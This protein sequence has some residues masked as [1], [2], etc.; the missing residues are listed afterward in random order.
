MKA[1]VLACLLAV[2]HAL[3]RSLFETAQTR[4]SSSLGA[5]KS[6][7]MP[8]AAD[9]AELDRILSGKQEWED[10]DAFDWAAVPSNKPAAKA[11]KTSPPATESRAQAQPPAAPQ[12]VLA[13]NASWRTKSGLAPQP[14]SRTT[15][16]NPLSGGGK[17]RSPQQAEGEDRNPFDEREA[18][19]DFSYDDL[20]A[21]MWELE[22]PTSSG[23]VQGQGAKHT[24]APAEHDGLQS[25]AIIDGAVWAGLVDSTY[26][27]AA[28]AP[29]AATTTTTAKT[30]KG[31]ITLKSPN[32]PL[33]SSSPSGPKT[34]PFSLSR[35][36]KGNE[37][38]VVIVY[39]DPRRNN[40]EFELTLEQLAKVPAS[41]LKVGVLA[42]NMD[43]AADQRKW[44]KRNPLPPHMT[45]ACDPSKRLMESL[46]AKA[47]GRLSSV[48][49][50]LETKTNRVLKIF[51]GGY[52]VFSTADLLVEE[53]R[54]YRRDPKS[55][56]Q[57]QIGVR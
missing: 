9:L 23:L 15:S 18:D 11:K 40:E 42:V 41:S 50:L 16:T 12:P 34:P 5:G 55:F 2:A 48:L 35:V 8:S 43:D 24:D 36:S 6:N 47:R 4:R 31:I 39:A 38:D 25:G 49:L 21:A 17:A 33:S 14:P 56:I 10:P 13:P 37:L 32:I 7:G 53:L 54:E 46:K 51:Y 44:L 57:S 52:D 28:A 45:L 27:A 19:F 26:A 1:V 22:G 20:D 29:A 30:S 3:R